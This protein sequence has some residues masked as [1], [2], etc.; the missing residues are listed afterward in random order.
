LFSIFEERIVKRLPYYLI[1]LTMALILVACVRPL[2]EEVPIEDVPTTVAPLDIPNTGGEAGNTGADGD[3]SFTFDGNGEGTA[4]EGEN[5][6]TEGGEGEAVTT[7]GEAATTE[8]SEGEAMSSEGGEG[9][10]V[11]TGQPPVV[12]NDAGDVIHTVVSGDLMGRIAERYGVTVQDILIVNGL[13]NPDILSIDDQLIIPTSGTVI[14]PDG[15]TTG[16]GSSIIHYV[17]PGDTLFRIALNYGTTVEALAAHNGIADVNTLEV[18][19]AISI[20]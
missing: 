16:A 2:Q 19:Q 18:G 5:A 10:A 12:T 3:T 7:D 4:L 14:A 17:L 20:P 13:T 9:E 8:G 11:T 1:M 15:S 6:G